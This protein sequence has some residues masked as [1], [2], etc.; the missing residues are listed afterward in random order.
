MATELMPTTDEPKTRLSLLLRLR[1]HTDA[2][3]WSDFVDLYAPLVYRQA[4]RR[5]FQ[6]AD[7]ADLT[8]EVFRAVAS[9]IHHFDYDSRRG[10]FRG[11][12]YRITENKIRDVADRRQATG[13][14][15]TATHELL[16]EQPAAQSADDWD[17]EFRD[18]LL[19]WA[20]DQVRTRCDDRTWQAFWLTAIEGKSGEAVALQLSMSIGTVYVAKSRVTIRLKE[21]LE[22]W[23]DEL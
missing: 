6:D 21:I 22:P 20:Y 11:W 8:Q 18:N 16:H 2:Q 3:A 19:S 9:A 5:G 14:G 4:R 10:E 15:D 12:L 13:A 1:D 23:K 7:A 17:R